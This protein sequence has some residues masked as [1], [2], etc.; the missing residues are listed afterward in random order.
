MNAVKEA[1][2]AFLAG[3]ATLATICGGVNVYHAFD[4]HEF[5][6]TAGGVEVTVHRVSGI[7]DPVS[8]REEIYQITSSGRDADKVDEAADRIELILDDETRGSA[9]PATGV[10]VDEAQLANDAGDHFDPADQLHSRVQQ[11]VVRS[12][13]LA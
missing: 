6:F 2:M 9:I 7:K 11:F 3:D 1:V 13:S 8:H 5:D 12:T 10:R 4:D